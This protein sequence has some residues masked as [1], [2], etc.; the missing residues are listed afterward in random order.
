MAAIQAFPGG[1]GWDDSH[2]G[3]AGGEGRF[4]AKRDFRPHLVCLHL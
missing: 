1:G 3:R 4:L 2:G